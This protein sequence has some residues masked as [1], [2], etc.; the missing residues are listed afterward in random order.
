[1]LG[2]GAPKRRCP[3]RRDERIPAGVFEAPCCPRFTRYEM[4]SAFY[5][6]G[7]LC[8]II[9][10]SGWVRPTTPTHPNP[11]PL[12]KWSKSVYPGFQPSQFSG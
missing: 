3:P 10:I 8:I 4:E 12:R 7:V 2:S 9:L 11:N 5:Q 1:M 6:K